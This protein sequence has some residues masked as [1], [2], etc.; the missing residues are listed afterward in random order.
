MENEKHD[1]KIYGA[2]FIFSFIILFVVSPDSYTHDMLYRCDS[3]WFFMCGKAWMN[4]MVPYVDFADSKGPFLW[5]IYGIGYLISN[6]SFIG[7]FWLS[8]LFYSLTFFFC[9]KIA[10]LF[11]N[12]RYEAIA[13]AM[14]MSIPFFNCLVHYEVRA[15]DFCQ[16]FIVG[17]LY[18]MLR[19]LVKPEKSYKTACLFVGL[20]IVA[21]LL[22]KWSLAAMMLFLCVPLLVVAYRDRHIKGSIAYGLMGMLAFAIP[23]LVY[24]FIE[25]NFSE[26]IK[27]YFINTYYTVKVPYGMAVNRYLQETVGLFSFKKICYILYIASALLFCKYYKNVWLWPFI[28]SVFFVLAVTYNALSYYINAASVFAI[29]LVILFVKFL[30]SKIRFDKGAVISVAVFTVM[31]NAIFV[32][33]YL[34]VR[35]KNNLFFQKENRKEFY[36]AAYIVGQMKR[37]TIFYETLECGLDVPSGALPGCKYWSRQTG[38][39]KEMTREREWAVANAKPDFIVANSN[40]SKQV[41]KMRNL[42]YRYYTMFYGVARWDKRYLYG[43]PGLKLPPKDFMPSDMDIFLKKKK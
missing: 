21:C 43:R 20:S 34:K 13:T 6:H 29:F 36:G 11:L 25:G 23:F 38:E 1:L 7:V 24:F 22:I 12:G 27:E 4:G 2:F 33:G 40:D 31:C 10:S 14:L 9:Y 35:G 5:L 19:S 17:S 15:E 32:V 28:C 41:S 39:T 26:F 37:P 18:L 3:S 30:S 8:V 16:P 42:G